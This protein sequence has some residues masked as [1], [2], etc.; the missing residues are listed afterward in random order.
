MVPI[1]TNRELFLKFIDTISK[2]IF[3]SFP[4]HSQMHNS[5]AAFA[6]PESKSIQV[7]NGGCMLA[8]I[9]GRAIHKEQP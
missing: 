6:S 9:F 7:L 4:N 1:S 5:T 2:V 3:I 8:K